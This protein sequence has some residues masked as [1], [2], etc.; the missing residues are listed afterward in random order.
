MLDLLPKE[1]EVEPEVRRLS[2]KI[3]SMIN[4]SS[5]LAMRKRQL[6][7]CNVLILQK[8]TESHSD[9]VADSDGEPASKVVLVEGSDSDDDEA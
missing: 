3:S 9:T 2:Y 5:G 1:H 4:Q 7:F 6:C 8:E